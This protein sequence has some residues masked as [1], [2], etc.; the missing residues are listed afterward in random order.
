MTNNEISI[1]SAVCNTRLQIQNVFW[2]H[3]Y[4]FDCIQSS[5]TETLWKTSIL[6][7]STSWPLTEC[8]L[9]SHRL[10]SVVRIFFH[11]IMKPI[12]QVSASQE[13]LQTSVESSIE[14]KWCFS[15]LC[16]V[17][18]SK[19][20]E[21]YNKNLLDSDGTPQHFYRV[22]RIKASHVWKN[23]ALPQDGVEATE[24]RRKDTVC[25]S[26]RQTLASC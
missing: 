20:H 25:C 16:S 2:S 3:I 12:C 26:P 22:Q 23:T 5:P 9:H 14:Y 15:D 21:K 17:E 13:H 24:V 8:I 11:D 4:S 18:L 19:M 7:W 10:N 6:P 1:I